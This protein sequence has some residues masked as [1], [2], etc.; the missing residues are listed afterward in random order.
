MSDVEIHIEEAIGVC[1]SWLGN[2]HNCVLNW[3]S[4][5]WKLIYQKGDLETRRE[6]EEELFKEKEIN[7]QIQR[8][9][10]ISSNIRW[11][12]W[13][14]DNFTC[15]TCGK[16]RNLTVDHI[17]PE[18]KGGKLELSNLQTLCNP[19]NRKKGSKIG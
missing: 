7:P 14:R 2:C 15:Q 13:E 4:C 3:F 12:V 19:C 5:C 17:I 1:Q 8:K 6:I 16:R 10:Y 11:Q 9:Q 18:S